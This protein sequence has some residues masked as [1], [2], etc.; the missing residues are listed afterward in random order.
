MRS[1]ND[2]I[3]FKS[4][5]RY[6]LVL[7]FTTLVFLCLLGLQLLS[8]SLTAFYYL[9]VTLMFLSFLMNIALDKY[10]FYASFVLNFLQFL[11]Y[12]YEY[13]VMNNSAAPVLMAMT[14]TVMTMDLFLQYY[15]IRMANKIY[16]DWK[17]NK[18]ERNARITKELEEEMFSRTSLIVSHEE[19]NK[20]EGGMSEAFGENLAS[21]IDP[22]TTLPGREMITAKIDRHIADDVAAMQSSNMPDSQ[23]HPFTI[24]YIGL[25]GYEELSR[26]IGHKSMDLFIQNMAHRV[27]EAALP[28]DMVA[29][30]VNA[31]FI[32]LSR[33]TMTEEE[34][35]AY[36][37][38]LA[39]SCMKAFES[40]ND[41]LCV[42]ISCG[43]SNYPHDGRIAG[44]L[45][46][47]A[48]EARIAVSHSEDGKIGR[49]SMTKYSEL[50][51]TMDHAG[52]I[53]EG[54]TQNEITAIFESAIE[55]GSLHMT[56]QPCFTR[57]R[58]LLGFEAFMKF[59]HDG[60]V[61]PPPVL[62]SAAENAGY[63]NRIGGFSLDQALKALA[64]FNANHPGLTMNL[65]IS[66]SQLKNPGFINML[67]NAVSNADCKLMNLILDIPEEGL[68]TEL[69]D[70]KETIEKL[71]AKGVK[72]ALDNFG[73]GYS[74]FNAIPL[75][76]ITVLK[77][78]GNFTGSLATEANVR[79][80]ASSVI[81]LMH[82]I[83]IKVCATGVGAE[84]QFGILA[85]QGCDIFQGQYLGP[86]MTLDEAL[87]YIS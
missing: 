66:T 81:S 3:F 68:F 5:V 65:N 50:A 67:S 15:I 20:N 35:D 23:R 4:G 8:V 41:K 54:K 21:S 61:I 79:V 6:F 36:A 84:G 25:D 46:A 85:E 59:E 37:R 74:S 76:P 22:L 55:D 1:G 60:E 13:L 82:D 75:L 78:D 70:I 72:M 12:A 69:P 31:E 86:A 49:I 73:R 58:E 18:Q 38:K 27:R 24:T 40:G 71:S 52:K 28:S 57:D 44:E 77:L 14:F 83:D 56:Y 17:A 9:G 53:F 64:L 2:R 43:V 7:V 48:E 47:R 10:G 45:I 19:I 62:L 63:M 32:V 39:S 26:E 30:L 34:T 80:L 29:R 16:E 42:G 11:A 87:D 33:R 51:E